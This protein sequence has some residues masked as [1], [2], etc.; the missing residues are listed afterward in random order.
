MLDVPMMYLHII[1][2]SIDVIKADQDRMTQ[3]INML[4][5]MILLQINAFESTKEQ[6]TKTSKASVWES[7]GWTDHIHILKGI[8][9]DLNEIFQLDLANKSDNMREKIINL[10]YRIQ[11][12]IEQK[13]ISGEQADVD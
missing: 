2:N 9:D 1:K 3:T 7:I 4:S 10:R 11:Q 5:D 8:S 13:I 12:H 6:A